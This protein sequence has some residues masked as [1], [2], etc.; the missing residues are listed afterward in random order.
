VKDE[1]LFTSSFKP[2]LGAANESLLS[3]RLGP[4]VAELLLGHDKNVW[5]AAFS[6][7]H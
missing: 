2:L 5:H 7:M 6:L 1:A 4:I 3:S